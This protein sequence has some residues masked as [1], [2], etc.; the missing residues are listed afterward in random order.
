MAADRGAVGTQVN[1]V[2]LLALFAAATPFAWPVSV[3]DATG[4]RVVLAAP[5][6]RVVSLAP[7]VTEVLWAVGAGGQVAGVSS[8]D[9]FPPEVRTRPRVGGVWVDEERLASLRPDLVVGIRSLQENTLRR[10]RAAGYVVLAVEANSLEET[11]EVVL[12]LGRVT[13]HLN[14]AREVVRRMRL[15]QAGV[16]QKVR[17]RPAVRVFVQVWDQPFITAASHTVT[18]D[19]VRHAGGHNVFADRRGWPQVSEE[20]AVARDPACV[21]V[22]GKGA[23]RLRR[24]AAWAHTTA[25]R[26]G[27][28][29]EVE[30]SWV[31]RPGPRLVLGLRAVA[32]VLHPEVRW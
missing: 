12:L 2:F 7:S 15:E 25:V 16:S 6:R 4:A 31:V 3:T 10:L 28:V 27:C 29:A 5:P 1:V 8:A 11:Y 26:R 21:L 20:E 14:Q 19:V 13:G 22:L 9:D 24:R 18:D 30:P 23:E 32:R 17:G